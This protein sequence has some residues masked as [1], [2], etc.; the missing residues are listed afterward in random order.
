MTP[1]LPISLEVDRGV[2]T[3]KSQTQ[4][5]LCAPRDSAWRGP[6]QLRPGTYAA[7]LPTP[8]TEPHRTHPATLPPTLTNHQGRGLEIGVK[9]T[10][11]LAIFQEDVPHLVLR[12]SEAL[13][14][15]QGSR[16]KS[17]GAHQGMGGLGGKE[18]V[19]QRRQLWRGEVGGRPPSSSLHPECS[20]GPGC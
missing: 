11:T 16:Q 13:H 10:T 5:S 20:A 15:L 8:H 6:H 2:G 1:A 18:G 17:S 9:G 12:Q 14:I 19:C 7:H 3:G 4:G